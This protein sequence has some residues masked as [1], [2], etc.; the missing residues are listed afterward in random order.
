MWLV[1]LDIPALYVASMTAAP[2]EMW[3]RGARAIAAAFEQFGAPL[4]AVAGLDPAALDRPPSTGRPRPAAL[5][6]PPS[7]R[8]PRPAALKPS[9]L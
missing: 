9:P 3:A 2:D 4:A 5:D 8:R 7:T 6:P 1:N